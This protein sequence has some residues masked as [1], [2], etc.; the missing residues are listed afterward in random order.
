MHCAITVCDVEKYHHSI[1]SEPDSVHFLWEQI[2]QLYYAQ[3]LSYVHV[4]CPLCPWLQ[5][6]EN[7]QCDNGV[8]YGKQQ[9][10]NQTVYVFY[11]NRFI[12]CTT[13]MTTNSCKAQIGMLSI[14][15]YCLHKYTMTSPPWFHPL[16]MFSSQLQLPIAKKKNNKMYGTQNFQ[17]RFESK[18]V[19]SL[20]SLDALSRQLVRLSDT[21]PR[22]QALLLERKGPGTHCLRMRQVSGQCT[23]TKYTK[24]VTC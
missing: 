23:C 15:T 20:L 3:D 22:T 2:Y 5:G 10:V 18:L 13:H 7:A 11:G 16:K 21:Q 8:R 9:E 1:G 24:L 17:Q 4:Q 6:G 14:S 12:N 19:D